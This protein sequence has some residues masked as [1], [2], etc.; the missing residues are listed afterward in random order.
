MTHPFDQLTESRLRQTSGAKWNYHPADVLPLWVADMDFPVAD[1]IRQAIRDYADT[2]DFGYPVP[3]GIPGL[4]DSV[5]RHLADRHGVLYQP[6]EVYPTSGIIPS[7]F[8]STIALAGPSDE[9]VIQPPVYPPFAMAVRNTGRRLQ[10]NP[11]HE[12]DGRWEF[13]LE[14]L[15]SAITPATRMLILCNPQ[16]P[17]GRVFTRTELE[18]LGEIVLRHRLWVVSD[19]LHADLILHGEHVPFAALSPELAQR[20]I[21]LFGPTK[22]YNIAGLKV[23][24]ALSHNRQLL[25]SLKKQ[26]EGLLTPP[27][28]LAQAAARAAFSHCTDWR[29]DAVAYIRANCQLLSQ[30]VATKLPG[31]RYRPAEGTYLA[32]LDFRGVVPA[33][34]LDAFM[35]AEA[36]VAVNPGAS[37]GEGGEGFVRLNLATSATLIREAID[38]IAAALSARTQAD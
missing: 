8:L 6:D 30:L 22:T 17:T 29:D 9:V 13:D 37:F 5:T 25:D 34:E 1:P 20:T 32:W 4:L 31:V 21:T 26:A 12:V 23:G 38:R 36:K 2:D 24:F 15:E 28:V 27:N 10:E 33:D 18:A 16:N 19:E 3:A 14:Q 35:M 11:M 7:L